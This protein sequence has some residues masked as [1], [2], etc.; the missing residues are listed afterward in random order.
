MGREGFKKKLKVG[1]Q[2]LIKYENQEL[3][4]RVQD[5]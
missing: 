5:G 1:L 3:L 4:A 2:Y